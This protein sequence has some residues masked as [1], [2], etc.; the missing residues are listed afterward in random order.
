MFALIDGVFS[1]TVI[2]LVLAVMVT[3][4]ARGC[5]RRY[6]FLNLYVAIMLLVDGVRYAVLYRWGYSSVEYFWAFFLTDALL[7]AA[8]YRLIL[9]FFEVVF[10]DTPLAGY[11]RKVLLFLVIIIAL[12]SYSMVSRTLPHFRSHL[13]IEFLQNMYFAA[14]LLAVLAWIALQHL[15]VYDRQLGFLIAGLGLSLGAQTAVCALQNLL[16]QQTFLD[17]DPLLARLSTLTTVVKLGLWCY[18]LGWISEEAPAE[19][20][21]YV[22]AEAGAGSGG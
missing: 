8:I 3:S 18:A 19:Q 12:M 10:R 15:R 21:Q 2:T 22:S 11:V 16:S 20:R 4:A 17:W 9:N 5:L 1:V 14:V 13:I 7:V 6:F